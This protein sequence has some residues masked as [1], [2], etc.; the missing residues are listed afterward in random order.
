[1]RLSVEVVVTSFWK[2]RAKNTK[3][4]IRATEPAIAAVV[5]VDT[6]DVVTV[7]IINSPLTVKILYTYS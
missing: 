4:P 5:T 1:M 6:V 7:D 3:I 2:R